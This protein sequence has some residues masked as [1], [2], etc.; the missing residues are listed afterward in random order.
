MLLL[1][2]IADCVLLR[3]FLT[4]PFASKWG[5]SVGAPRPASS[6]TSL[7]SNDAQTHVL[8]GVRSLDLAQSACHLPRQESTL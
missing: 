4:I 1:P 7:E 6:V 3:F 5:T 2:L 8:P